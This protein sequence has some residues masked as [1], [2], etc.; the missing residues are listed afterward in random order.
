MASNKT[1]GNDGLSK[2]FYLAFFDLPGP[3]LLEC[4]N[5]VF[6]LGE[7]STSQRQA[8]VTLVEKKS[9]D[10]RY[11]KNWRPISLL[12]VDVKVVSK[13]LAT[14]LKKVISNLVSSDQTAYVPDRYIGESVRLTSDL[15]EY[16][17]IHNLPGYMV[18]IDIEK[19]FDS[20]NHTFLLCALRKYGFGNN[21][22]KY[23][24]IILNRQESC[25]MNNGHSTGYFALSSGTRQGD[26]IS[27][28]LFI[29]VM[30]V[31]FIQIRSN[32]NIRGL[33]IFDY[34]IKLTSF[35]DDVTCFLRD[36]TSIEHLLSLLRYS[37]QFTSLKINYEKSEICGIGSKKGVSR[38]FSDFSSVD[39]ENDTV[40]IL[41]FHHSYNKQLADERNFSNMVTDIH[42]VLNLWT[43]RG[44]SLIGKI[45]I[46]KTL[47]ISRL[48]YITSMAQVP[49]KIIQQLKSIQKKFLWESNKPRIKHS[50]LIGDYKDGGGG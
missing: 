46:F 10:K 9:R 35:A 13:V 8:V 21:F 37:H 49:D 48:Q 3:K 43:M 22:I 50:T 42:N 15:L 5:K 26:P 31:L 41:G 30:E 1:P 36:F 11:I 34:E 33:K 44:I 40:K 45:L 14:R 2:E 12:N 47:G 16:T 29:L 32:K 4:L 27:A 20:V 7:F 19:A 18:T 24:K 39:I 6:S 17:N 38:A 23:V 25:I 28:Y